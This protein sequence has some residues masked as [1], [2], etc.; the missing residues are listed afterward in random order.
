MKNPSEPKFRNIN[1]TNAAF[2]SRVGD[3][4]GGRKILDDIGF[5]EQN[6]TYT[7]KDADTKRIS[8]FIQIIDE[9]LDRLNH[10]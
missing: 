8:Q 5:S 10:W 3:V 7:L 2:K 9:E 6:G 4:I 1:P